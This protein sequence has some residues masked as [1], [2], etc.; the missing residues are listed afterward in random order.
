MKLSPIVA[1]VWLL[2]INV[3]VTKVGVALAPSSGLYIFKR[4]ARAVIIVG[5]GTVARLASEDC[6]EGT[7]MA[8]VFL[9]AVAI[10]AVPVDAAAHRNSEGR[11]RMLYPGS[12]AIIS[13]AVITL[14]ETL[15]RSPQ[16]C[17][18]TAAPIV[19]AA[20]AFALAMSSFVLRI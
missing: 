10:V 8:L 7:G 12:G 4:W 1:A 2:W 15:L 3:I 18:A 9:P 16:A 14:A 19:A 6:G 17:Y 20:T 11:P 13:A 5:A